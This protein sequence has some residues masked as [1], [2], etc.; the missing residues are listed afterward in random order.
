LL[1]IW[2]IVTFEPFSSFFT[3]SSQL[4]WEGCTWTL[5]FNLVNSNFSYSTSLL[6]S[7]FFE[8]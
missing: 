1:R 3:I 8:R 5:L 4:S 2:G 7:L 6:S